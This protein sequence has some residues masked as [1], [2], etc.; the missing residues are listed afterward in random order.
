[1]LYPDLTTTRFKDAEL[2]Y[3]RG[4]LL[5][6]LMTTAMRKLTEWLSADALIFEVLFVRDGEEAPLAPE[7]DLLKTLW[8]EAVLNRTALLEHLSGAEV[9]DHCAGLARRS[10]CSCVV[11]AAAPPPLE[12]QGVEIAS[13][14]I[15]G[16][17]PVL[18]GIDS[19]QGTGE[20]EDSIDVWASALER[21][22]ESWV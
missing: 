13:L 4:V 10:Q 17:R 15:D 2:P 3:Q 19:N 5:L 14:R 12:A 21:L 1:V 22:L 18:T 16:P 7:F 6:A 8:R 11:I 9:A 20:G